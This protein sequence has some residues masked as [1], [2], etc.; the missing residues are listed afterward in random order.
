MYNPKDTLL[1]NQFPTVMVPRFEAL[2]PCEL[3]RT[4]LL[5]GAGGL[6]I[7][8]NQPW[9]RFVAQLWDSR[10]QLPYGEVTER[11]DFDYLLIRPD[12]K[13]ILSGHVRE[14]AA[15]YADSG[16]EWAGWVVWS[17]QEGFRYQG[18]DLEETTN[19][20]VTFGRQRLSEGEHLVFD[21]HSHGYLPPFFS[22][23]DDRD[24]SGGIKIS[25]VLGSYDAQARK[26]DHRVRY[27]LEGIFLQTD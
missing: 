10:R 2:Q 3:H 20:R 4:R 9:G 26:F 6:Y 24:D 8:T 17:Q 11:N 27:C 21:I 23:T 5:M 15:R 7:E 18:L 14:E 1:M 25:V 13:R 19:T 12:V 16:L 22:G